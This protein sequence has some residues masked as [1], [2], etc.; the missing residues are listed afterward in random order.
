MLSNWDRRNNLDSRGAHVFREFWRNVDFTETTDD[1]FDM[2]FDESDP[3]NTPR[4]L[5]ITAGT[6][7]A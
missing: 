6:R 3:I 1:A 4:D 5:K 7:A 2:P